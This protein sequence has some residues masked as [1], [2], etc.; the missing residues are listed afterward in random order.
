MVGVSNRH[1]Y[2]AM[3]AARQPD[4]LIEY[5]V[6]DPYHQPDL[7]GELAGGKVYRRGGKEFVR[8]TAEQAR[9]YLDSGSIQPVVAEQ[10]PMSLRMAQQA[11]GVELPSTPTEA[12]KKP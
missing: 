2:N 12:P 10:Q 11:A 9:F 6:M 8:L 5:Q 4:P 1:I 7:N 3:N